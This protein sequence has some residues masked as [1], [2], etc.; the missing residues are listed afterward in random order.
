MLHYSQALADSAR[1]SIAQWRLSLSPRFQETACPHIQ[2]DLE[3]KG[4][5]QSM[6]CGK[7]LAPCASDQIHDDGRPALRVFNHPQTEPIHHSLSRVYL[8]TT[9]LKESG[10]VQIAESVQL[11]I[12]QVVVA[13]PDRIATRHC[14][15]SIGQRLYTSCSTSCHSDMYPFT[16]ASLAKRKWTPTSISTMKS[17]VYL[18]SS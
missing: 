9:Y 15:E 13:G 10:N 18:S 7:W 17:P 1:R 14:I 8:R 12:E 2:S 4:R 11:R 3:W 16:T 6:F 5:N